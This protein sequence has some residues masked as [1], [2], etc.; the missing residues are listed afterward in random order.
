[1]GTN[2]EAAR[3]QIADEAT[4]RNVAWVCVLWERAAKVDSADEWERASL[5]M[6][7]AEMAMI[8]TGIVTGSHDE[9]DAYHLFGGLALRRLITAMKTKETV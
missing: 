7:G 1:M 3:R 9:E 6:F 2:F 4:E 8:K 5:I